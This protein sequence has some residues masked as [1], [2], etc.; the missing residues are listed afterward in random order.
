MLLTRMIKKITVTTLRHCHLFTLSLS[1]YNI[2]VTYCIF[3]ER[4][5]KSGLIGSGHREALFVVHVQ[6]QVKVSER[7]SESESGQ[8]EREKKERKRLRGR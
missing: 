6:V 3:M 8:R 2:G 5:F 7:A 1:Q 4:T